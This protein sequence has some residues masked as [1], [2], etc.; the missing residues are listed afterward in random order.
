MC[1]PRQ[2]RHDYA[3]GHDAGAAHPRGEV[4]IG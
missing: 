2:A 3:E 4:V 1:D